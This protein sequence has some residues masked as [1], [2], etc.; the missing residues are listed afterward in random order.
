MVF[1][2]K[3]CFNQSVKWLGRRHEERDAPLRP[4]IGVPSCMDRLSHMRELGFSP[5]VIFDCGAFWGKWALS[6]S[7]IFPGA[8][9]VLIE[10]NIEVLE[11]L[12]KNMESI[13][14]RVRVFDVAV[15]DK[16]GKGELNIWDNPRHQNKWTALA[17][18]SL[19]NH[20]QGRPERRIH[21]T[22]K[23]IDMIAEETGAFPDLLKLDLQ[24]GE[25]R[26]LK[27]AEKSLEHTELCVVEFGCLEAYVERTT[28]RELMDIM[29]DKGF[30]L[31]DIVD[32]RYRPYDGALA[33]G[34]FFYVRLSS[35]LREH[36]DY[37]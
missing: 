14:D 37:F 9:L 20:I 27:G 4:I 25:A 29:Y 15:S 13:R 19:L 10:P 22:I 1:Q 7:H 16:P 3:R 2:I 36:R 6:V 35:K 30:C 24:G 23:T 17:A 8:N 12:R 28:P 32:L 34:D 33:G 21:V 31:Y 11:E 18:S 5:K 26:A